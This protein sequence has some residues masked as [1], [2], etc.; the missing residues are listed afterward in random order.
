MKNGNE[1]RRF[2]PHASGPP[3]VRQEL[4]AFLPRMVASGFACLFNV[5]TLRTSSSFVSTAIPYSAQGVLWSLPALYEVQSEYSQLM[6]IVGVYPGLSP[7]AGLVVYSAHRTSDLSGVSSGGGG[8][9][10]IPMH[11][12]GSGYTDFGTA[13][14][15]LFYPYSPSHLV[16]GSPGDVFDS[17]LYAPHGR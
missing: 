6:S 9:A 10:I 16:K 5:V 3:F 2:K 11:F 13:E 1:P 7:T 12:E 8:K 14:W 4:R 15:I 17:S